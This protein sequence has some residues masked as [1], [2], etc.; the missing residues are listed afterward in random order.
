MTRDRYWNP[1]QPRRSEYT[2]H[3]ETGESMP[4]LFRTRP[5]PG[6]AKP[7]PVTF[8]RNQIA[9]VRLYSAC[10]HGEIPIRVSQ[11]EIYECYFSQDEFVNKAI[12]GQTIIN[13][14]LYE[15]RGLVHRPSIAPKPFQAYTFFH[16]K[17][18]EYGLEWQIC[19]WLWQILRD[20][21][22]VPKSFSWITEEARDL[23]DRELDRIA[24]D[25]WKFCK[26]LA[27]GYDPY[28][29]TAPDFDEMEQEYILDVR[30]QGPAPT[31]RPTPL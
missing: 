2:T 17:E 9:Q 24:E 30:E 4:L 1:A 14:V 16:E 31:R 20:E 11:G 29:F 27:L 22:R 25:H 18:L 6:Y 23:I 7:F 10:R 8:Y 19:T 26:D 13:S 3:P 5:R 21:G 28:K 15:P 12:M